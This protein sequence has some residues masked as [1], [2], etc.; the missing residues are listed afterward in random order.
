MSFDQTY[1]MTGIPAQ[2]EKVACDMIFWGSVVT[3]TFQFPQPLSVGGLIFWG[4]RCLLLLKIFN[5]FRKYSWKWCIFEPFILYVLTTLSSH[6]DLLLLSNLAATLWFL[7]PLLWYFA[8]ILA[9]WLAIL[10]LYRPTFY[11]YAKNITNFH[12]AKPRCPGAPSVLRS[13]KV[14]GSR[15][16][17]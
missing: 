10:S 13:A 2:S 17:G 9:K 14:L 12:G 1:A 11:R 5:F 3:A 6:L 7:Q 8:A 16:G 15:Q 4:E